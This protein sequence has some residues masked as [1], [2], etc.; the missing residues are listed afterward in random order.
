MSP[1]AGSQCIVT[2]ITV[3]GYCCKNNFDF[4]TDLIKSTLKAKIILWKWK[5]QAY[6]SYALNPGKSGSSA[7]SSSTLGE[8][9][10]KLAAEPF[11][12]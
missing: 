6:V 3:L 10:H 12:I 2:E 5:G 1:G 4:V 7:S 8:E 11:P 9:F